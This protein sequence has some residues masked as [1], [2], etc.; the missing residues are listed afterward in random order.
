LTAGVSVHKRAVKLVQS[1]YDLIEIGS[2]EQDLS[3]DFIDFRE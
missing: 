2:T 1:V 3:N